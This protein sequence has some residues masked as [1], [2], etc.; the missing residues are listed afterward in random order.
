LEWQ[1][2]FRLLQ[3]PQ[4]AQAFSIQSARAQS[5]VE[6][7]F[8]SMMDVQKMMSSPVFKQ[9]VQPDHANF[10]TKVTWVILE[11]HMIV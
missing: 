4:P 3:S 8:D 7:W 11:E 9:Q 1:P 10:A 2:L 6:F 5:T